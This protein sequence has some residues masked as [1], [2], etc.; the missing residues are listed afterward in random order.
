[1]SI[2]NTMSKPIWVVI[3]AAVFVLPLVLSGVVDTDSNDWDFNAEIRDLKGS[4][5]GSGSSNGAGNFCVVKT[6]RIRENSLI[7]GGNNSTISTLVGEAK[8]MGQQDRW[9]FQSVQI[10][11]RTLDACSL[12]IVLQQNKNSLL[13]FDGACGQRIIALTGGTGKF[14]C[15]RGQ[16]KL[17]DNEM[18]VQYCKEC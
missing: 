9:E 11:D 6:V 12:Q 8:V 3:Y 4:G 18:M 15:A 10:G 16:A 5:S 7:P 14:L 13:A 17:S 1:M 2:N